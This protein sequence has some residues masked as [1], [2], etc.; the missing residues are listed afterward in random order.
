[1][2]KN[3]WHNATLSDNSNCFGVEELLDASAAS[4]LVTVVPLLK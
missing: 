2:L 4:K 3:V 1:M